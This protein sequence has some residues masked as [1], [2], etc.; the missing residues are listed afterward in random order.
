MKKLKEIFQYLGIK[1]KA[2]DIECTSLEVDSRQVKKGSL[3]VAL[4]GTKANGLDYAKKAYE[5]GAVAIM[6]EEGNTPSEELLKEVPV[7]FIKLSAKRNL[8]EFCSFFYD[9]PSKR[10]GLIGITGTNGKSTITQLIAQWLS[11]TFSTKCAVFGTLGYGFLPTL[12]KS[13]NTTLDAV[14]LQQTLNEMVNEGARF[15]A[16]EVS[17]IGVC[18]G[19]ID[20]CTFVAGGFT[21]LTRDHL[22]YHK[23]MENYAKAKEDFLRRV[24]KERLVINVDNEQGCKYADTFGKCVAY[25]CKSDFMGSVSSLI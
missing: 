13:S 6:F 3:F 8:G 17:S 2:P 25:S 18:E 22:D 14:R 15:A 20:G 10:L 19:R 5:L 4:K 7:P 24:P 9:E 11:V 16:L 12:K 23:T 21:N 1:R